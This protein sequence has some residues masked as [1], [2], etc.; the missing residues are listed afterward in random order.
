MAQPGEIDA[1]FDAEVLGDLIWG[2][3][4]TPTSAVYQRAMEAGTPEEAIPWE[5]RR[6][7]R[8][9]SLQ[10]LIQINVS[11]ISRPVGTDAAKHSVVGGGSKK[12]PLSAM[13][14]FG[15]TGS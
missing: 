14:R 11:V 9:V 6:F 8:M 3:D 1:D 5:G 13:E 7:L 10:P 4:M 12:R 15:A 2:G